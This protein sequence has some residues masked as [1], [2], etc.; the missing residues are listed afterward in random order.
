M[1]EPNKAIRRVNHVIPT[2]E[3]I[4]DKVR[5]A[6]YFSKIDLKNGY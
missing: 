6:K 4:K 2:I 3:E 5:G 1:R